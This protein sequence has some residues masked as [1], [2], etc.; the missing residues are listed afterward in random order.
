MVLRDY[1]QESCFILML[2]AMA[3]MGYKARSALRERRLL[4]E[5]IVRVSDGMSVLPEDTRE[6]TR[7]LQALPAEVQSYLLPRAAH[8]RAA[9]LRVHPQRAGRIGS[10]ENSVRCR[11]GPAGQRAVHGA[12]H[13]VGH[14]FHRLHR[15]GAAVSVKRWGQAHTKRS[16]G[17]IAGVTHE[18]GRRVQLD[19]HR[20]GLISIVLMFLLHQLQLQ[21]ERL[22]LD[23]ET[24]LDHHLIQHLQVCR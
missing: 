6:Y 23:T 18:P 22:V 14:S 12:L 16:Q 7:P 9:A 10:R 13:R 2:W 20:A 15:N 24:Y 8:D 3:I 5:D 21:Q 19:V 4:Q 17:D 11:V 1:E